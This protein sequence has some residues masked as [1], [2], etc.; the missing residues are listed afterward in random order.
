MWSR[1]DRLKLLRISD[2]RLGAEESMSKV[3]IPPPHN[4]YKPHALVAGSHLFL[5]ILV[6]P[7]C[8]TFY[9]YRFMDC[10]FP[11]VPTASPFA[12]VHIRSPLVY[13]R[14]PPRHL[15]QSIYHPDI[16]HTH[17]LIASTVR[18]CSLRRMP[19]SAAVSL[20]SALPPSPP[21]VCAHLPFIP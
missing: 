21:L 8:S 12:D 6:Y 18:P 1:R 2:E 3:G 17:H 14:F 19:A 4:L 9:L 11:L 15:V 5:T 10:F 20:T 13:N 7:F 16:A